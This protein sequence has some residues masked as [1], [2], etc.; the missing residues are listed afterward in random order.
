MAGG[1][2]GVAK[3]GFSG[4]LEPCGGTTGTLA[5]PISRT[6]VRGAAAGG[7]AG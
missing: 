5:D 7:W 4:W 2:G 1:L 6:G 3:I